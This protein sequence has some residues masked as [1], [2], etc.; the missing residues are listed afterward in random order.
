VSA[1]PLPP[2]HFVSLLPARAEAA[3]EF[4][5]S[6][7]VVV[8][9]AP[10]VL[11]LFVLLVVGVFPGGYLGFI[12]EVVV[13]LVRRVSLLVLVPVLALACSDLRLMGSKLPFASE[14]EADVAGPSTQPAPGAE[15][16]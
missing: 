10:R 13:P 11:S 4:L 12:G 7:G 2:Q 16:T 6:V 9:Q 3:G 15:N 5:V 1:W 14:A 8:E